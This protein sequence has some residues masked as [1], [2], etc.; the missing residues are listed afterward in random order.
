[1]VQILSMP[2]HEAAD[3]HKIALSRSGKT[4]AVTQDGNAEF[5]HEMNR[6]VSRFD[7][8]PEL[9]ICDFD[10]LSVI[11]RHPGFKDKKF[12]FLKTTPMIVVRR[13]DEIGTLPEDMRGAA[14]IVGTLNQDIQ[15]YPDCLLRAVNAFY[16]AKQ[17][18][19]KGVVTPETFEAELA[20]LD[21]ASL[22]GRVLRG[23]ATDA[24]L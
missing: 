14:K 19:P 12:S 3:S 18:N 13:E 7:K 11:T 10:R 20:K 17:K 4:Y 9:L 6:V 2:R 24:K 8:L 16:A 23:G 15:Y 22:S 5:Y 21:K 1:M